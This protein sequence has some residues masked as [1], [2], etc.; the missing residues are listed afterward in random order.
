MACFKA[1]MGNLNQE[2]EQMQ[3]QGEQQSRQERPHLLDEP[4]IEKHRHRK[5]RGG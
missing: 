5:F 4:R 2:R 3:C 1:R